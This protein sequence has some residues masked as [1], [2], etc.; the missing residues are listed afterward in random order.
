MI[1]SNAIGNY[2]VYEHSETVSAVW[3]TE[4]GDI[5]DHNRMDFISSRIF[6]SVHIR[7]VG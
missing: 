5:T 1:S 7:K 6:A 3:F 4:G 2:A